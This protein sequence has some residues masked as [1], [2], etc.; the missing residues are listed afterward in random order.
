MSS[1]GAFHANG[2][3]PGGF[4]RA[5][6]ITGGMV[7]RLILGSSRLVPALADAVDGHVRVGTPDDD[8]A[9]A[10]READIDVERIEPADERAL[11]K[12]DADIVF[13]LEDTAQDALVAARAVRRV[14]SDV[15]LLAYPGTDVQAG[16]DADMQVPDGDADVPVAQTDEDVSARALLASVA[17]R[18]LD[19]DRTVAGRV[20][21]CVAE[22]GLPR[23]WEVLRDIDHLA[24]VTHDNPDPDA[25]ASGVALAQL[26]A[27]A[28][29]DAEVCHYGDISHQENRAFV[30]VLGIDLRSL[31]AGEELSQFDGFA[32]V[33]HARPGVNDQLPADTP[34]DIIIDHH[35]PRGPVEARF[36]DLR[37]D[38]GA[39]STLLVEYLERHGRGID[40]TVATALLFGIHVDTDG[41]TR[42]VSQQDFEAAATLIGAAELSTLERIESPSID[43][44]TFDVL[45]RAIENRRVEGSVVLSSV[46]SIR[47]RDALPQA[48]DKLLQLDSI[49]TTLV[50]GIKDGVVY[51]SARSCADGIDIGEALRDAFGQMGT[52]GGHVDMAGGQLDLGLLGELDD[53]EPVT[54]LVESLVADRFLEVVAAGPRQPIPLELTADELDRYHVYAEER[55]SESAAESGER[56]SDSNPDE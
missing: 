30:N 49:T 53:D 37:S 15:Y 3:V 36:V 21:E 43:R 22:P 27:A 41:F 17:D 51:L 1:A 12:Q 42:G 7:E 45:A 38:V 50:Y 40:T 23:L 54:K 4:L 55:P 34:V 56:V 48:A 9:T 14:L 47:N 33:D 29:C 5:A 39:T 8:V 24:V 20:L 32:L 18:V 13:V 10:V 46:G 11:A 31:N 35:P 26:A 44:E 19:P 52:A 6:N 2:I 25:I 28:G 16:R